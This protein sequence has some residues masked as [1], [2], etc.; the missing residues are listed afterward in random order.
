[1]QLALGPSGSGSPP[2]FHGR[3]V[4]GLVVG[5][6]LW[7]FVPPADAEF[8]DADAAAWGAAL[9]RNAETGRVLALLQGPRDIV[10]VPTHWGHGVINLADSLAF[11]FEEDD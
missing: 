6:K 11:A 5:A 4:N 9:H 8:A 3:A 1:M 7:V 2:H 10:S